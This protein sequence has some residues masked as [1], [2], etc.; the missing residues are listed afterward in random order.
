MKR[1][2][3]RGSKDSGVAVVIGALLLTVIGLTLFTSFVLWYV[4]YNTAENQQTSLNTQTSAFVSLSQQ[5]SSNLYPGEVVTQSIQLGVSGVPPFSQAAD[6]PLSFTNNTSVF[7]GNLNYSYNVILQNTTTGVSSSIVPHAVLNIT[8]TNTQAQTE[9]QVFQQKLV[10]DSAA[11]TQYE[12]KNLQNVRFYY[13]NGT[14]I[15]SWLESGNSNTSTSTVYWLKLYGGPSLE[16]SEII[17]MKFFEQQINMFNGYSTGESPALS[18]PY[19]IYDNGATVFSLYF[20]GITPTSDFS[21]EPNWTLA[22][23]TTAYGAGK[24]SVLNLTSNGQA[25][26]IPIVYTVGNVSSS[27]SWIEES[28]FNAAT[29]NGNMGLAGIGSSNNSS[30]YGTSGNGKAGV[31][32]IGFFANS[33]GHVNTVKEASGKRGA[34]TASGVNELPKNT[35][36]YSELDYVNGATNFQ[37]YLESSLY[38]HDYST[39]LAQPT[40]AAGSFLYLAPFASHTGTAKNYYYYNWVRLRADPANGIMPSNATSTTLQIFGNYSYVKTY[41]DKFNF[42][43]QFSVNITQSSGF[44]NQIYFADGAA[45]SVQ[46]TVSNIVRGL[47]INLSG[48]GTN[49]YSLSF[50]ALNIVGESRSIASYGAEILTLQTTQ[51]S[52]NS[53][54]VGENLSLLTPGYQPYNAIVQNISMTAFS[55]TINGKLSAAF[56]KSLYNGLSGSS[57]STGGNWSLGGGQINVTLSLDHFSA[58][59]PQYKTFGLKSIQTK[60]ASVEIL[61]M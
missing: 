7:N 11:Y 34:G 55:Y 18:S 57:L 54:Y 59:L 10:I 26:E 6:T 58:F 1:I 46:G 27:S 2:T 31:S 25:G 23:C 48:F 13:M 38:G 21:V 16:P 32:A 45:A 50:S 52:D 24:I 43:G 47:P 4:P 20:N 35:W 33:G 5:L 14:V 15:P 61:N 49:N 29:R 3:I 40:F 42:S 44:S 28:S 51:T 39:A 36:Y 12:A 60:I 22:T 37:A 53:Y 30:D 9:P 8:I 19:G 17:Q 56:N 41:S